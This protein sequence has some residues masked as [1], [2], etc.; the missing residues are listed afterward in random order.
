MYKYIQR[1]LPDILVRD[2][3][4]KKMALAQLLKSTSV[5]QQHIRRFL[6]QYKGE[7]GE[8]E[9]I[10]R[11]RFS[12]FADIVLKALLGDGNDNDDWK[13]Q[14]YIYSER[15]IEVFH[16]NNPY[17]NRD[18]KD[19]LF[20]LFLSRNNSDDILSIDD[21]TEEFSPLLIDIAVYEQQ[22]SILRS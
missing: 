13:D 14:L 1:G 21:Y 9:D 18:V 7:N 10:W 22:R 8:I 15:F 3:F 17:E 11:P 20:S 12:K 4:E 19:I 5:Q 2:I 16:R 6:N